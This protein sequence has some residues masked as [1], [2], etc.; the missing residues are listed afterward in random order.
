[1]F[2]NFWYGS[3]TPSQLVSY[4]EKNRLTIHE[5]NKREVR[6][7][8]IINPDLVAR[9]N[10]AVFLQQ[11]GYLSLRSGKSEQYYI[12]D[13]PNTEVRTSLARSVLTSDFK[14]EVE[15]ELVL[16]RVKEALTKRAPDM[17]VREFNKLLSELSYNYFEPKQDKPTDAPETSGSAKDFEKISEGLYC[18]KIFTIFYALDVEQKAEKQGNLGRADFVVTF[19]GNTWV[20]EV[21]VN[22]KEEGDKTLVDTAMNQIKE[23]NYAGGFDNPVLLGICINDNLRAVT[24]WRCE[25]GTAASPD[26]VADKRGDAK[27]YSDA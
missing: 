18:G 19:G 24:W 9:Y 11:L 5:F 22:H 10:P 8:S 6:R 13:Y 3:G 1:M 25:G 20:I 7:N 16:T 26:D 12:L 14:A 23:K 21:K 15:S 17:L 27:Y 4:L 2:D